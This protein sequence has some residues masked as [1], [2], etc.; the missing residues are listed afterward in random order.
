MQPF[1]TLTSGNA[2]NNAGQIVADGIDSRTNQAHAYFLTPFLVPSGLEATATK[3]SIDLT[4]QDNSSNEDGFRIERRSGTGA[5]AHVADTTADV[6]AYSDTSVARATTYEY[7]VSAFGPGGSSTA[8]PSASAQLL[9]RDSGGGGSFG[10]ELEP[11][12][13]ALL[14]LRRLR[15][16]ALTRVPILRRR[17]SRVL[18]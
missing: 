5:W 8:S 16:N 10:F 17:P 6:A 2:I 1:V 13:L 18:R 12:L 4:W 9:K 14:A 11:L 7:R 15:A 3:R